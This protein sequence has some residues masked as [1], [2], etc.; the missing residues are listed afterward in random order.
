V[1]VLIALVL[2]HHRHVPESF[3]L[4]P[5]LALI[6]LLLVIGLALPIATLSVC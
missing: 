1:L 2:L 3:V 4:L 6:Q 5:L